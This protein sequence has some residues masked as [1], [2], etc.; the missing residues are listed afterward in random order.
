MS[1]AKTSYRI[2]P[3]PEGIESP[4]DGHEIFRL[5]Q[6]SER[7]W[8]AIRFP[9]KCTSGHIASLVS[10]VIT[11]LSIQ[12]GI[13]LK[14]TSEDFEKTIESN[15]RQSDKSMS[16]GTGPTERPAYQE[17][18]HENMRPIPVAFPEK[19]NAFEIIRGWSH[20]RQLKLSIRDRALPSD[21]HCMSAI[22]TLINHLCNARA[23]AGDVALDDIMHDVWD[24]LDRRYR[25]N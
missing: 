7:Y 20:D 4:A 15:P 16:G 23:G 1:E 14:P 5:W 19:E 10:D 3:L 17:A 13:I 25:L 24:D 22:N 18:V 21:K 2:L 8:A 11:Q 6:S 12:T 9:R